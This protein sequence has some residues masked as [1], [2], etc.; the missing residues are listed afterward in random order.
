MEKQLEKTSSRIV[1]LRNLA[2]ILNTFSLILVCSLFFFPH[3]LPLIIKI[4]LTAVAGCSVL[5]IF[6]ALLLSRKDSTITL[7]FTL[8]STFVSG[9]FIGISI[10][11]IA[12]NG[13]IH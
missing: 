5:G 6:I 1:L 11:A 12:I 10:T 8:F 2:V 13:K 7:F 4:W 9:I 3:I